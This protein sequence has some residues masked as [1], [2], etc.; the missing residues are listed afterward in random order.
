MWY[1]N[2]NNS[3]QF[4]DVKG[5]FVRWRQTRQKERGTNHWSQNANFVSAFTLYYN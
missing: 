3:M 1:K 2:I 5:N 4:L